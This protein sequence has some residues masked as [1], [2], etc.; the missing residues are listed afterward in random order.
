MSNGKVIINNFLLE[1]LLEFHAYCYLHAWLWIRNSIDRYGM[2]CIG[3][4]GQ[5]KK[6]SDI[7]I[8]TREHKS[9]IT[10]RK[11]DDMF[12]LNNHFQAEKSES[13]RKWWFPSKRYLNGHKFEK[14][15][16]RVFCG[17]ACWMHYESRAMF[18][19]NFIFKH[20]LQ[21]IVWAYVSKLTY[22]CFI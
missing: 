9:W 3:L 15:Y 10:I 16:T 12:A 19:N 18:D 14:S 2:V 11:T 8:K 5:S 13:F 4:L 6:S 22:F 1:K 21:L 7:A 20:I 17:Y